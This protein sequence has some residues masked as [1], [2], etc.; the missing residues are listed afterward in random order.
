[1]ALEVL[2]VALAAQAGLQQ[3]EHLV[4][5][6]LER[7]RVFAPLR[8]HELFWDLIENVFRVIDHFGAG[9]SG[10]GPASTKESPLQLDKDSDRRTPPLP[11]TARSSSGS[12]AP[13][14]GIRVHVS[15]LA[16]ERTRIQPYSAVFR[17]IHAVL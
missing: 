1:M 3:N 2:N 16:P 6:I 13:R 5:A 10:Q 7:Q 15:Q 9:L 11:T 14:S 4:Y 17:C 8:G 12:D